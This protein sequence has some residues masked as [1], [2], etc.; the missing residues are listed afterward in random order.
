[1]GPRFRGD[2][3]PFQRTIRAPGGGTRRG[4]PNLWNSK[5]LYI[6][7]LVC[8][9]FYGSCLGVSFSGWTTIVHYFAACQL[10]GVSG[11]SQ[12]GDDV[13]QVVVYGVWREGLRV[14]KR[15]LC[16]DGEGDTPG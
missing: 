12:L 1:M 10:V 4:S 9:L 14:G 3:P 7:H 8:P 13:R 5:V 11:G 16:R 15:V 6:V 2:L